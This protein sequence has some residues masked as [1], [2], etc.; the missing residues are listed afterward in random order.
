VIVGQHKF[1]FGF[2]GAV[3]AKSGSAEFNF[4]LSFD[5]VM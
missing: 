4:Y 1:F 2:G 3:V 5:E